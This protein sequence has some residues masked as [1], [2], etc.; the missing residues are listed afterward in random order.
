LTQCG[1]LLRSNSGQ[2]LIEFA[3]ILPVT[4]LL[5]VNLVN[6]GALAYAAITVSNAARAGAQYMQLGPNSAGAPALAGQTAVQ[7][8][9]KADMSLL[10]NGS[11]ATI[12][13]CSN[14]S[15]AY[16]SP[17]SCLP[18]IDPSTSVIFADPEP[19]TSVVGTVEID[20]RYCPLINGWSFP[21][22][23]VSTTLPACTGSGATLSGGTMIKREA[24]MRILQ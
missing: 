14:N 15:G 21:K 11:V 17:Y 6:F 9:V 24:A 3:F 23:G 18:P 12:N 1:R 19:S 4:F 13:V 7:N 16:E 20:Y 2:S 5:V 10:P 22:L 8:L